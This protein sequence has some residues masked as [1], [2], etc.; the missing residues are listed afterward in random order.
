MTAARLI[1]TAAQGY[2][3]VEFAAFGIDMK[4]R[5]ERLRE[6]IEAMR[7]LWSGERVSF[8]GRFY[9]FENVTRIR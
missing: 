9:A 3:A 1:V 2:R 7:L 8:R 6:V 4:T 5:G